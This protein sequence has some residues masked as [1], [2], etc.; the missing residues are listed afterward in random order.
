MVSFNALGGEHHGQ[1]VK[2]ESRYFKSNLK[3]K[4]K[5]GAGSPEMGHSLKCLGR[6]S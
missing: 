4:S 1:I 5:K 6:E 2:V 3:S